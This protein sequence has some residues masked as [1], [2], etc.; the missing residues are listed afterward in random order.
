MNV[1]LLLLC[2]AFILLL[3]LGAFGFYLAYRLYHPYRNNTRPLDLKELQAESL[4]IPGEE[5]IEL[6]ALLMRSDESRNAVVVAHELGSFK[7]TKVKIAKQLVNAGY[8]VLLF[9]LRNHG[10]SARDT[11]LWPMSEKFTDDVAAALRFCK[12]VLPGMESISLYTFSFST[13]PSLY[14]VNRDIEP[15]DAI[16]LD[17]GPSLEIGELY[18]KFMDEMGR[19]LL[20]KILR[21]PPMYQ[22]LKFWFRVIGLYMLATKWPPDLSDMRS[23]VLFVING[24]DPI[25]SQEQILKIAETIPDKRV[26]VSPETSHLQAYRRNPD[27]YKNA[28]VGFLNEVVVSRQ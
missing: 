15:P 21:L 1:V 25:F 19:N 24:K 6:S 20:P 3:A 4:R 10:D 17:S 22:I 18:G 14:I 7:E 9:D 13:F 8:N 12:E 11:G 16:I 23:K 5:G 2:T 27:G 26:W 28:L